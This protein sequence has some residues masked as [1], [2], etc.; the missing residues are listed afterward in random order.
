[1]ERKEFSRAY[2]KLCEGRTAMDKAQRKY[3]RTAALF[4]EY[5]QLH[6]EANTQLTQL[7]ERCIEVSLSVHRY[8]VRFF[9]RFECTFVLVRCW[10]VNQI[11]AYTFVNFSRF[12]IALAEVS[13]H[14]EFIA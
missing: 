8:F 14:I 10:F 13:E 2:E 1:M 9:F 11:I 3:N 12:Q 6:R 7:K 5:L 4:E